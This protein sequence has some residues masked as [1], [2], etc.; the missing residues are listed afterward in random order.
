MKARMNTGF[1]ERGRNRTY[2]YRF[3]LCVVISVLK[4]P[5]LHLFSREEFLK[6]FKLEPIAFRA[7]RNSE[8]H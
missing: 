5:E 2:N 8:N 4:S 3:K 6:D 7:K 1:G